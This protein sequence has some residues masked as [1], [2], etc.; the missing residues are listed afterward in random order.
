[1][2]GSYAIILVFLFFG[3]GLV[4][5]SILIARFVQPR[6]MSPEKLA[7][8]ECGEEPRGEA[9]IRYNFR[10]YTVALTFIIFEAEIL[11]MFPWAIVYQGE[12]DAGHGLMTFI[13]MIIFI[14]IL[15]LG[16][17]YAWAKGDLDWVKPRPVFTKDDVDMPAISTSIPPA[18]K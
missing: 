16:L 6:N 7:T 8:Y 11:F 14:G 12:I 9:R 4:F 13:K 2:R 10:F 18:G 3:A 17:V 1:M 15:S 5:L